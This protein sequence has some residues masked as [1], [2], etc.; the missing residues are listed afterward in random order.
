[1]D[2]ADGCGMPPGVAVE[3][4]RN[5]EVSDGHSKPSFGICFFF[6]AEEFSEKKNLFNSK[7]DILKQIRRFHVTGEIGVTNLVQER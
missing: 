5:K 3:R 2:V 7:T 4:M 1:M 6:D